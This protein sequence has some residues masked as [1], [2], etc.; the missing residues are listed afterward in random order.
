M[1]HYYRYFSENSAQAREKE[2]NT[3]NFLFYFKKYLETSIKALEK[4]AVKAK[5]EEVPSFNALLE[6]KGYVYEYCPSSLIKLDEN[7]CAFLDSV[8]FIANLPQ[9]RDYDESLFVYLTNGN[10][11]KISLKKEDIKE[12]ENAL[13]ELLGSTEDEAAKTE[14]TQGFI[15]LD[16]D[17]R[18]VK[19]LVWS[20]DELEHQ[21]LRQWLGSGE[22]ELD[23]KPCK[24]KELSNNALVLNEN[25]QDAAS[26]KKA[27]F[28]LPA[29]LES[30]PL[31]SEYQVL[32][33]DDE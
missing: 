29:V 12:G 27:G 11:E 32:Y 10:K 18:S 28:V 13:L 16:F 1:K 26:I 3:G 31:E 4:K 15:K 7:L 6:L 33:S 22:I 20:G 23:S 24:I 9:E 17:I 8:I 19:K 21:S 14:T 2:E 30:S 5:W 25:I